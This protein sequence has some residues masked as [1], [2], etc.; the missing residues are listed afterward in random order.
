[1]ADPQLM[2]GRRRPNASQPARPTAKPEPANPQPAAVL[3]TPGGSLEA[4]MQRYNKDALPWL[5]IGTPWFTADAVAWLE[6][7]VG[8]RDRVF[9]LG[10][11][12]S[13]VWWA[14]RVTA[15]HVLE[16]SPDW[17]LFL[18]LYL[19]DKPSLLRRVRLIQVPAD[20]HPGWRAGRKEYWTRNEAALTY[21]DVRSLEADYLRMLEYSKTSNILTV[22]G[23][24]R[25]H[26]MV[27]MADKGWFAT[28]EIVIADNTES[29][30]P[31]IF[32]GNALKAD[33][34]RLDFVTGVLRTGPGK[35]R[36]HVT[37][38]FVRKDIASRI[39][40]VP[41]EHPIRWPAADLA[42][43][44]QSFVL[45]TESEQIVDKYVLYIRAE[46]QAYGLL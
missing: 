33:F 43:H 14:K 13:T 30:F 38:A 46:L 11:G 16:T 35:N 4:L 39:V 20:W 9:E 40:T 28:F 42:T 10:G 17:S 37:T 27:L 2:A 18:M 24:L 22:D 8:V 34:E 36:K 44:H 41:T 23:G 12:R 29:R 5:D 6:A 3:P 25:A 15:V 31:S 26:S 1:M 21:A 7:N 19:Y 32:L 45:N